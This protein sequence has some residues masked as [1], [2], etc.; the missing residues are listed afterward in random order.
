MNLEITVA[1]S[2]DRKFHA[3]VNLALF[4]AAITSVELVII[5]VPIANVII[6]VTVITL[7]A[8]K[9]FG[10]ILWFMHLVYDKVLCSVLFLMGLIIA[11]GTVTALLVLFDEEETIPLESA[12][13]RDEAWP[14]DA[15]LQKATKGT[16]RERGA[17]EKRRT[18]E[19][20]I[21]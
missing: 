11:V 15:F 3:F 8:V 7:S 13:I 6:V 19:A 2:E 18:G 14:G 1:E 12:A 9:F 20:A 17:E 21:A 16:K 4:M 10:V 5:F